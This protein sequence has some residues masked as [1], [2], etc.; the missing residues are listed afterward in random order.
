MSTAASGLIETQG[1]SKKRI[2]DVVAD[3]R[4]ESATSRKGESP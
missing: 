3:V 4:I 1:V 2:T